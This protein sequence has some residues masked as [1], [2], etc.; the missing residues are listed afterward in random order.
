MRNFKVERCKSYFL[1]C[2]VL[3]HSAMLSCQSSGYFRCPRSGATIYIEK[4]TTCN[5]S[6]TLFYFWNYGSFY[7]KSWRISN[8]QDELQ[9][10]STDGDLFHMPVPFSDY[11]SQEELKLYSPVGNLSIQN[12]CLIYILFCF[13]PPNFLY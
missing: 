5:D 8:S 1:S 11:A 12:G 2:F 10:N 13:M 4:S 3:C 9:I 7:W 6:F